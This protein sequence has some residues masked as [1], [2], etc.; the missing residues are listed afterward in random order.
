MVDIRPDGRS[1]RVIGFPAADFAGGTQFLPFSV[2]LFPDPIDIRGPT[3][4]FRPHD[5][6]GV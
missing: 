4:H 6:M 3:V 2:A 1:P 5:L